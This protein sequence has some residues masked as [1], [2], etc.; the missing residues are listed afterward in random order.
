MRDRTQGRIKELEAQVAYFVDRSATMESQ[1]STAS[2]E[3]ASLKAENQSLSRE[4]E[5][6]RFGVTPD[7]CIDDAVD[8]LSIANARTSLQ[9]DEPQLI[10]LP[11]PVNVWEQVPWNTP[12]T[13]VSDGILYG[14]IATQ[15]S[16]LMNE[17]SPLFPDD[18]P[19]LS[20]LLLPAIASQPKSLS[21]VIADIVLRYKEVNTLP[22]KVGVQFLMFK[23]LNVGFT[24][25]PL[26]PLRRMFARAR[27]YSCFNRLTLC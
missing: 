25:F 1:L 16:K 21:T 3:N 24:F 8:L 13:C 17:A 9:K 11:P 19:D 7:L 6:F 18:E 12:P 20:S 22:M 26:L 23:I 5:S 2:A 15:R 14:Y 27:A 4:L 10:S